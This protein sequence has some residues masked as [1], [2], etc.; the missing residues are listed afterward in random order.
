[1]CQA[2][3]VAG[4]T[5]DR[6]TGDDPAIKP[7]D[8]G[9]VGDA[10]RRSIQQAAITEFASRGF[11][12]TSMAHIAATAGMSR[13]ALYQYFDNK[14]DIFASAMTAALEGA[15]D[16]ALAELGAPGTVAE[17]L[18][19]FLQRFEGDL[20]ATTNASPLSDELIS[21]KSDYAPSAFTDA[22]ERLQQGLHTYLASG[23]AGG[24]S[25]AAKA[26]RDSWVEM[27]LLSPK[28]F[29]YDLPS[30]DDYRRRLTTLAR[31]V[32]ADIQTS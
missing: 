22:V 4:T 32:A 13:P 6:T 2:P 5:N 31:S 9:D 26:R 28:G 8:T 20:W 30:V 21:A 1:M 12:G 27:L 24:R 25:A 16:A 18:D 10:K 15:V 7:G 14:A 3:W 19:G 29:K 17:Q 11:A 23:A